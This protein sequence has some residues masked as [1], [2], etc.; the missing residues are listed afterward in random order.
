MN[1]DH[2]EHLKMIQ[3]AIARINMPHSIRGTLAG[4]AETRHDPNR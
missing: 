2:L 1:T 3:A 4:T